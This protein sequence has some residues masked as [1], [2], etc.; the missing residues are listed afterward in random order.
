MCTNDI[1]NCEIGVTD[2]RGVAVKKKG[3]DKEDNQG[4]RGRTEYHF[5]SP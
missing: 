4:N 5:S 1:N 3:D 2:I